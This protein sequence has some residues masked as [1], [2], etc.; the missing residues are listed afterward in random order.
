MNDLTLSDFDRFFEAL[1]NCP[2]FA[3]QSDLARRVLTRLD[4]PWPE[5]IALPTASGKTAIGVKLAQEFNGEIVSADSRQVYRG[6]D[7]GSGKD[8]KKYG[9]IPY[10]LIDV[11]DPKKVFDLAQYKKL[12]EEA[13]GDIIKRG[14][15]PIIVGGSGLYLEALVDNYDLPTAKPN[16]DLRAELEAKSL[17]ELQNILEIK[18]K[19]FFDK[20]NNSDR[21]NK[22]RLIRYIEIF[23]NVIA[24]SEAT[25]QSRGDEEIATLP[26]VARDDRKY[27]A[28]LIGLTWPKEILAERIARR[29]KERLDKEDMVEE[30]KGL[31]DNGVSWERLEAFG[32][33]YKFISQYLQEK[34]SYE[35]MF[36]K[37]NT[38]INQFAKRQMTWFKRWAKQGRTIDWQ[39]DYQTILTKVRKFLK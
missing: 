6:L 32:L 12:A 20:L 28:F 1:W 19:I 17:E 3:W 29:L 38:A 24:R 11:A 10:H 34:I 22:R 5:V 16:A 31:H 37:L 21:N 13:I 9:D 27:D 33:E 7:V 18:N 36:D 25:R 30:V 39:N 35:E 8:L 26:A 4:R 15:L 14:K 23:N 2:P